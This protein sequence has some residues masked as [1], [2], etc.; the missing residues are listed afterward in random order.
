MGRFVD[1]V[2]AAVDGPD[3]LDSEDAAGEDVGVAGDLDLAGDEI[4]RLAGEVGLRDFLGVFLGNDVEA[5][6]EGLG[7]FGAKLRACRGLLTGER[8]DLLVLALP[9]MSSFLAGS[10]PRTSTSL[11]GARKSTAGLKSSMPLPHVKGS[12]VPPPEERAKKRFLS[13]T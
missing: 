10:Q 12:S 2:L 11:S 8:E 5:G 7:R 3:L 13:S 6:E 4:E 9:V 1:V